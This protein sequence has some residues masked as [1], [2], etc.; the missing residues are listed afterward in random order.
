MGGVLAVMHSF[1]DLPNI[2]HG[3]YH[4]VLYYLGLSMY[5]RMLFTV[6][7]AAPIFLEKKVKR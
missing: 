7:F 3:K 6:S 1:L 4:F 2:I 5:P